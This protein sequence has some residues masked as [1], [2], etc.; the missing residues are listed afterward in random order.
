MTCGACDPK[1]FEASLELS[2]GAKVFGYTCNHNPAYDV[3]SLYYQGAGLVMWDVPSPTN[4]LT[5]KSLKLLLK[6]A[7]TGDLL[8]LSGYS[9]LGTRQTTQNKVLEA[10]HGKGIRVMV[11]KEL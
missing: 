8:I 9:D 5:R 1:A 2:E 4:T 10:I 6:I 3:R 7:R 11:L